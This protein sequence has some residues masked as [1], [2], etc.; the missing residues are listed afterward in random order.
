[1]RADRSVIVP[2]DDSGILGIPPPLL[3]R[4]ELDG[5]ARG[6]ALVRAAVASSPLLAAGVAGGPASALFDAAAAAVPEAAGA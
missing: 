4:A 1:M 6:L 3:E 5:V 2:E